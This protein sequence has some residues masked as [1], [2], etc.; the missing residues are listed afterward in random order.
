MFG[1]LLVVIVVLLSWAA[2]VN[3]RLE[4]RV[5][6]MTVFL[7]LAIGLILREPFPFPNFPELGKTS[8]EQAIHYLV[9]KFPSQTNVLFPSPLPAIASKMAYVSMD[10]IPPSIVSGEDFWSWLRQENVQAI[11]LDSNRRVRNDIYDLFEKEYNQFFD[12]VYTSE[13]N[14]IRIFLVN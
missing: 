8:S 10:D 4:C 1:F 14:N 13:E 11:Y 5:G 6:H 12:R 2:R 3:W 7:L 9:Q